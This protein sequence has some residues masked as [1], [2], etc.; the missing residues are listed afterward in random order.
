MF[1]ETFIQQNTVLVG[2]FGEYPLHT[3]QIDIHEKMF[4]KES[5]LHEYFS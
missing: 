5:N 4:I 2:I 3:N 1:H